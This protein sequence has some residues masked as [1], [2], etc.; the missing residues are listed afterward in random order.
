MLS[1]DYTEDLTLT[2]LPAGLRLSR[3]TVRGCKNLK[4]LPSDLQVLQ[5]D[6]AGSGL[7]ALPENFRVGSLDLT[8]CTELAA[9]PEG[10]SVDFLDISGCT[11]LTGW[12]R[13]LTLGVGRLR[14]RGCAWLTEL[15]E[16]LTELAQ[17]DLAGCTNLTT[18]PDTLRVSS[19][20]DVAETG[21][22]ELPHPLQRTRLRWN[23]VLVEARVVFAPET[24]T[25]HDVLATA[26]T[27]VRRVMLERIGLER[28]VSDVNP[29]VLDQDTDPGGPRRL[30]RIALRGDEDLV[31]LAVGCP[32]TGREYLL[33][34]PP[35]VTGC[36]QAA[37][38]IA[39]FDNPA[40]YA[41]I[42]ET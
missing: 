6:A 1:Q 19:W 5:L 4:Q 39:G 32:S 13:K 27:E 28:F 38:W 8:N 2:E 31:C 20:L 29:Q 9:L 36:H 24:L 37:A 42:R 14:A 18:L 40:D 41:P 10:L 21:I 7:V 34:V 11:K 30:L 33:R 23:G 17:L 22:T 35:V 12:P 25:G 16:S 26:N 3:L 15:P